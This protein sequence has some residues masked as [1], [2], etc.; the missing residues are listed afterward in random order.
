MKHKT[1]VDTMLQ[2][3]EEIIDVRDDM[4]TEENNCNY[5]YLETLRNEKYLP[6]REAMK[7]AFKEAVEEVVE[8]SI[9][10]RNNYIRTLLQNAID[11]E[12][13]KVMKSKFY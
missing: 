8:D 4:N 13:R 11:E 6:A 9:R 3:M 7:E 12:V 5:R 2:Y 10:S 1:D